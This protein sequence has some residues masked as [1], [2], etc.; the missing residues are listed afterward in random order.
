MAS[1]KMFQDL[2]AD[3]ELGLSVFCA[4]IGTHGETKQTEF[5]FSFRPLFYKHFYIKTRKREYI[6]FFLWE[7]G[8][9]N[10]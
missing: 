8:N 6:K 1:H 9:M 10:S 3:A 4:D 2:E 5:V 7:S